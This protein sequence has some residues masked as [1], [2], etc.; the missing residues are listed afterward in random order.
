MDILI[1]K[2]NC[3]IHENC[4]GYN[5]CPESVKIGK[6]GCP[7]FVNPFPDNDQIFQG[8]LKAMAACLGKCIKIFSD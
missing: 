5:L 4:R 3:R 7:Y 8:I 2:K 1:E 6:D